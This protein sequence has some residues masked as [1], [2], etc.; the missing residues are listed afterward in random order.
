MGNPLIK[1][2]KL[3]VTNNLFSAILILQYFGMCFVYVII[4]YQKMS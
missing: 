1:N 4:A 3:Y 2:Y